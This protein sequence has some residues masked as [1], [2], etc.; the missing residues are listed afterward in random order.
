M[1]LSTSESASDGS[2]TWR[3]ETTATRCN[4]RSAKS[5]Y[6]R[7][8]RHSVRATVRN[9]LNTRLGERNAYKSEP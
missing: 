3:G 4:V 1:N 7:T 5:C 2:V 9:T 6:A 8:A